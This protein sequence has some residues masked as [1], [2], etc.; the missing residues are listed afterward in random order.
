QSASRDGCHHPV[1]SPC[2]CPAARPT[3][4][5]RGGSHAAAAAEAG[6]AKVRAGPAPAC[7]A[8]RE[9]EAHANHSINA[10]ESTAAL[11]IRNPSAR[12]R[13]FANSTVANVERTNAG[14]LEGMRRPLHIV[15][16]GCG[17]AAG[18]L[19]MLLLAWP[20]AAWTSAQAQTHAAAKKKVER[21]GAPAK[22]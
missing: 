3:P 21:K 2:A 17:F 15:R 9:V 6:A 1:R 18:L 11:R 22:P 8:R 16:L 19:C 7:G 4:L 20:P 10:L 5:A 13:V 12:R 14:R